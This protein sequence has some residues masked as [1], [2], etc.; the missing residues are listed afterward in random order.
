MITLFL[1]SWGCKKRILGLNNIF[2]LK[3]SLKNDTSYFS[4]FF[5]IALFKNFLEPFGCETTSSC[6]SSSR[7]TLVGAVTCFGQKNA[8]LPAFLNLL[9]LCHYFHSEYECTYCPPTSYIHGHIFSCICM[10]FQNTKSR[11]NCSFYLLQSPIKYSTSN[12]S[13]LGVLDF[14]FCLFYLVFDES[15]VVSNAELLSDDC[16]E[17]G[18]GS[19]PSV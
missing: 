5:S 13:S 19:C 18:S 9:C 7:A 12:I 3:L 17:Y 1:N 2:Y 16:D 8:F 14:Y 6:V 15:N 10:I 11:M 4:V